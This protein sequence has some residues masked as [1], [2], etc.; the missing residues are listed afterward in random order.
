MLDAWRATVSVLLASDEN[1]VHGSSSDWIQFNDNNPVSIILNGLWG[2]SAIVVVS[3]K[4]C[5]I[6]HLYEEHAFA[7]RSDPLQD[8]VNELFSEPKDT[9]PNP[10]HYLDGFGKLAQPGEMFDVNTY[11]VQAY[12]VHPQGFEGQYVDYQDDLNAIQGW[13]NSLF[14]VSVRQNPTKMIPYVPIGAFPGFGRIYEHFFGRVNWLVASLPWGKVLVQHD[15]RFAAAPS[16]CDDR[17]PFS[18]IKLWADVQNGFR[19]YTGRSWVL[20]QRYPLAA[21]FQ[22]PLPDQPPS[23]PDWYDDPHARYSQNLAGQPLLAAQQRDI[24]AAAA[25]TTSAPACSVMSWNGSDAGPLSTDFYTEL[26]SY[27]TMTTPPPEV[28]SM[29]ST[30]TMPIN[31]TTTTKTSASGSLPTMSNSTLTSSRT[32]TKSTSTPM[33]SPSGTMPTASATNATSSRTTKAT[34]YSSPAPTSCFLQSF[35]DGPDDSLRTT[36]QCES[37][38]SADVV[39]MIGSDEYTTLGCAA[40]ITFFTPV[41][42]AAPTAT[43]EPIS[44]PSNFCMLHVNQEVHDVSDIHSGWDVTWELFDPAGNC[45][46]L[47]YLD[48]YLQ[49]NE[50]TWMNGSSSGLDYDVQ[51]IPGINPATGDP[52]I[53]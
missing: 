52:L 25:E 11:H 14:W 18:K 37:S 35:N 23:L 49:W 36:C 16:Y 20:G 40:G 42:T 27:L 24:F 47:Q 17:R 33:T 51:I 39:R 15:P 44:Q 45:G 7:L 9:S 13:L 41:S 46:G 3:D 43:A 34:S 2:C 50:G 5:W 53:L 10:R 29:L 4:G 48:H 38:L 19:E 31:S 22:K 8:V 1:V 6:S 12:I 21:A 32:S 28:S 26:S 30:M